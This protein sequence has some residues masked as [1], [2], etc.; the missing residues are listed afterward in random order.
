MREVIKGFTTCQATA[1]PKGAS[2]IEDIIGRLRIYGVPIDP[3]TL[4]MMWDK[5]NMTPSVSEGVKP[6]EVKGC[7]NP[8]TPTSIE[9]K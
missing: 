7:R 4:L 3:L 8:K 5:V 2:I 6:N 1:L 9:R